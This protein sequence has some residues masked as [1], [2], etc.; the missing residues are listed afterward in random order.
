LEKFLWVEIKEKSLEI[1]GTLEFD[2]IWLTSSLLY[3]I[4]RE[5]KFPAKED[6]NFE[7]L[8]KME[9]GLIS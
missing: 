2:E 6:Q 9:F 3:L 4:A 8:F 7:F 1:H 5:N